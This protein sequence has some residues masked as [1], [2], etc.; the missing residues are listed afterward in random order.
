MGLFISSISAVFISLAALAPTGAEAALS[1]LKVTS[2]DSVVTS[3]C[4][5]TVVR[6]NQNN[7]GPDTVTVK[8]TMKG[9]E[10]K[11]SVL[12]PRKVATLQVGCGAQGIQDP[13]KN[14]EL[15]RI[16]N[17][18]TL[19]KSR[20]FEI[21]ANNFTYRVCVSANYI[22]KNGT[23]SGTGTMCNPSP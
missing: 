17:A 13:T 21:E 15:G 14:V 6:Y 4:E 5:F 20:Y 2:S 22:L 12:S 23:L 10:I 9:A 19:Y 1:S 7:T 16:A 3:S 18:S 8:L 11:P